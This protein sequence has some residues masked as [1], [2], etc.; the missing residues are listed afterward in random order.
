[1]NC[2]RALTRCCRNPHKFHDT[3]GFHQ[4][5]RL[6]DEKYDPAKMLDVLA[7]VMSLAGQ[8]VREVH[9]LGQNVNYYRGSMHEGG[10]ADLFVGF[11]GDTDQYFEDTM[12]LID[13]MGFDHSYSFWRCSGR[14]VL[15]LRAGYVDSTPPV[16]N[17]PPAIYC[18]WQLHLFR[19]RIIPGVW[20]GR[21]STSHWA[22]YTRGKPRC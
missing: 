18:D 6:S 7:E 3:K 13:T 8:G 15:M 14:L 20:Q 12:K 17:T 11:P 16:M 10:S 4:D 22:G 1:M 21:G 5:I 2:S 9:L 19:C